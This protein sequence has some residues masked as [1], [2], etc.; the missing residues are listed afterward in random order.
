MCLL[1]V[2]SHTVLVKYCSVLQEGEESKQKSYRAVCRLSRAPAPEQLAALNAMKVTGAASANAPA[3]LHPRHAA[4]CADVAQKR[5]R[6]A[7]A[8]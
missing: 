5:M 2:C 8:A 6:A 4:H 1:I 3:P 7:Q